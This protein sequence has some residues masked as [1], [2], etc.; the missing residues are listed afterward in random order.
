MGQFAPRIWLEIKDVAQIVL[1]AS[2]CLLISIRFIRESL[3]MYGV[4]KQFRLS[5]FMDVLLREGMAY[6]LAYV[7]VSLLFGSS[8]AH[9]KSHGELIECSS[10]HS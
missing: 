9:P 1:G 3:L 7:R 8:A 6:F 2:M 4:A 10:L 5:S